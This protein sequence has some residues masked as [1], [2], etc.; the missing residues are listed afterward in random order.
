M[1]SKIVKRLAL[2]LWVLLLVVA[3]V[4]VV[5]GK[6]NM[7]SLMGNTAESTYVCDK[8]VLQGKKCIYDTY[9][10]SCNKEGYYLYDNTI[11]KSYEGQNKVVLETNNKVVCKQKNCTCDTGY[12]VSGA[13]CIKKIYTCPT[14]YNKTEDEK[15]CSKSISN[16]RMPQTKTDIKNLNSDGKCKDGYTEVTIGVSIKC[17]KAI[18]VCSEGYKLSD[19]KSTCIGEPTIDKRNARVSEERKGLIC[20]E[21]SAT[22]NTVKKEVAAKEVKP[23][24]NNNV[25]KPSKPSVEV[26]AYRSVDFIDNPTNV[27]NSKMTKLNSPYETEY[28]IFAYVAPKS[29]EEYYMTVTGASENITD[30][31]INYRNIK[32]QG[33]TTVKVKACNSA[34]CSDY[35]T[36][37]VLREVKSVL[38]VGNSKTRGSLSIYNNDENESKKRNV[39]IKVEKFVDNNKSL[40]KMSY[41]VAAIC[42]KTLKEIFND[43][44]TKSIITDYPYKYVVLQEQTAAAKDLAKYKEEVKLIKDAVTKR[45]PKVTIYLRTSWSQDADYKTMTEN[46]EKVATEILGNKK[47]VIY[48]GKTL[49]Q[50]KDVVKVLESDKKHQNIHGAYVVGAC[51]YKKLYNISPVGNAFQFDDATVSKK[52]QQIANN[53]C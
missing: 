53:N 28:F 1:T 4:L 46:A 8:G 7:R 24:N 50:S 14:G 48:D 17:R 39:A 37:D 22:V 19:S 42:N 5:L 43:N 23:N 35:T 40:P 38:F 27:D 44:S 51:I 11:G 29:N 34:G 18:P 41:R 47:N 30:K 31:K 12:T 10:Y 36:V 20:N 2:I 21:E 3:I 45:N 16:E 6:I 26:Y 15:V 13:S 25:V 33:K 9:E 32:A 49:Y 52:L